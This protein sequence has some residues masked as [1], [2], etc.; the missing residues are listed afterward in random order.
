MKIYRFYINKIGQFQTPPLLT[1]SLWWLI[2]GT[3]DKKISGK[4]DKSSK[5]SVNIVAQ[6]IIH[7][8][9]TDRQTSYTPTSDSR[10]R[11]NHQTPLSTGLRLTIH[12]KIEAR[13]FSTLYPIYKSEQIRRNLKA[14][15]HKLKETAYFSLGR[16]SLE[17]FQQFGI[18]LDKNTSIN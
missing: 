7:S 11:S 16:S 4:R 18:P 8:I 10:Y 2:I 17:Y 1:S 5:K 6:Q 3:E 15:P 13:L 14:C 12:K 9:K